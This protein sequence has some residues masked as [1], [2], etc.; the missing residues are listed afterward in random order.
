MGGGTIPLGGGGLSTRRHG[1][2]YIYIYMCMCHVRAVYSKY[3][4]VHTIFV[5]CRRKCLGLFNACVCSYIV[6]DGDDKPG[7]TFMSNKC[8]KC[9]DVRKR[10]HRTCRICEISKIAPLRSKTVLRPIS[11]QTCHVRNG[12]SCCII[13]PSA[14]TSIQT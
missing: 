6:V 3:V 14:C 10:P 11:L 4:D 2:I 1:T 13:P 9:S 5:L 12:R 7:Q 8:Q